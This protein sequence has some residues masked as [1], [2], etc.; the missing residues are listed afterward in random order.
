MVKT[1]IYFLDSGYIPRSYE[2]FS[3]AF[4]N[5]S[6]TCSFSNSQGINHLSNNFL[7]LSFCLKFLILKLLFLFSCPFVVGY[8]SNHQMLHV[9]QSNPQKKFP[10]RFFLASKWGNENKLEKPKDS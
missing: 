10:P 9:T 2:L 5:E 7:S 8:L 3:Y 1:I 4:V 6:F